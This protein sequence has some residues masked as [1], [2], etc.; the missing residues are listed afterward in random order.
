MAYT[1]FWEHLI[2][3][4]RKHF[5]SCAHS[6][7]SSKKVLLQIPVE[8]QQSRVILETAK[9]LQKTFLVLVG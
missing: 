3:S 7:L 8:N 9:G 1:N 6:N 4:F 5:V 2:A